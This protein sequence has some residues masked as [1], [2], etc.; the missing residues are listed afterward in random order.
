[1]VR[2]IAQTKVFYMIMT[3]N[4]ELAK[5][6]WATVEN[7]KK[8]TWWKRIAKYYR[9]AADKEPYYETSDSSSSQG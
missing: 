5:A 6:L 2:T 3:D 8:L 1:M 9:N 7:R 4:E